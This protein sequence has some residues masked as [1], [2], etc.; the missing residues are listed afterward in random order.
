VNARTMDIGRAIQNLGHSDLLFQ[1]LRLNG[2]LW[3]EFK[4]RHRSS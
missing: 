4:E 2:G 1:W 3:G